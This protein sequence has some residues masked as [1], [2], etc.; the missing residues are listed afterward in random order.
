[1]IITI[2]AAAVAIYFCLLFIGR[3]LTVKHYEIVSKKVYRE[4]R[5]VQISDLHGNS[6]GENN[7]DL[8]DPVIK[9]KPDMVVLTGDIVTD[10]LPIN[11]IADFIGTISSRYPCYYVYGN[12]ELRYMVDKETENMMIGC[13]VGVLN[14]QKS[15]INVGGRTIQV[16]GVIDPKIK[17]DEFFSQLATLNNEIDIT[18]L[19]VLLTHRPEYAEKYASYNFDVV[20]SGHAHGGHWRIPKIMNGL[21]APNQGLFPK[22]A[23]GRYDFDNQTLIVSRGLAKQYL[24]PRLFNPTEL[25]VIDIVPSEKNERNTQNGKNHCNSRYRKCGGSARHN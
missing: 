13:G 12:H 23:G 11:G 6:F 2:S 24:I 4:V 18:E 1:M 19:S 14:G 17:P 9:Q 10:A 25:V 22:Y 7:A 5:I 20:L 15:E 16:C 21:F 8:L 3:R